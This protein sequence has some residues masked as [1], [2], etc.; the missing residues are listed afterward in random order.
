MFSL[1]V[2]LL[3]GL[4]FVRLGALSS[5][6]LVEVTVAEA[7]CCGGGGRV[8]DAGRDGFRK[9]GSGSVVVRANLR[10]MRFDSAVEGTVC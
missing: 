1:K 9:V 4:S 8:A 10:R 2:L 3:R 6:G 7:E 5:A